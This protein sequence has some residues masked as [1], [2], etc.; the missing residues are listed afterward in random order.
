M[1]AQYY[2]LQQDYQEVKVSSEIQEFN[3]SESK[4]INKLELIADKTTNN[5]NELSAQLSMAVLKSIS[6]EK[7]R[8]IRDRIESVHIYTE[9][10]ALQ[11]EVQAFVETESQR[12]E[13]SLDISL[14]R[15]FTKRTD[16]S[17]ETLRELKDPLVLSFNGD[18]PSLSSNTFS[19]DIDSDG[20]SDQISL[21]N[22]NNAFLVL[23]KNLNNRIDN[24]SELFGAKSG[25]GFMDLAK[26]DEDSNGW[27][28]E[29]D[30][31]FD[32]LQVWKKS[33]TKDELIGL[34][35]VGIGAIFLGDADTPFSL[36]TQDN[37]L[38]GEIRKS[39]FFLYEN[40]VAGVV[41]QIDMA[42]NS[43]TKEALSSLSD[44][45]KEQAPLKIEDTYKKESNKNAQDDRIEEIQARIKDVEIKLAQADN[46]KKPPLQAELGALF[47]QMMAILEEN[48]T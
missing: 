27:I 23:D 37:E 11:Y 7:N 34:G 42:I 40:G 16:I 18:I 1:N 43:D 38:L 25:D 9:S 32:K 10:Q 22:N 44:I 41:S 20:E 19:F 31:I 15:S 8:S 14:S 30:A 28:D 33:D 5:D 24:G 46:D 45:Q 48:F 13:F 3:N 4:E 36:K 39:S 2:N 21:L 35:E 12:Y 6:D 29:N 26:Y 17:L 47:S